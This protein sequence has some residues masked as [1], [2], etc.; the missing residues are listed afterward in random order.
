VQ[1][2]L[3]PTSASINYIRI[4]REGIAGSGTGV[5]VIPTVWA[6]EGGGLIRGRRGVARVDEIV[7]GVATVIDRQ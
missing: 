6:T 7:I 5:L 4:D 2:T 3:S 1:A